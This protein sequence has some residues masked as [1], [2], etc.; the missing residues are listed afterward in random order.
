MIVILL[1]EARP[2]VVSPLHRRPES[3]PP[4]GAAVVT[5][6]G[7]G[8]AERV[9]RWNL[10]ERER[11]KAS[12][13]LTAP[14]LLAGERLR[15]LGHLSGSAAGTGVPNPCMCSD[16]AWGRVS[17]QVSDR[18]SYPASG[19]WV[20]SAHTSAV[21]GIQE[22]R[23]SSERPSGRK[24]D[25]N[26]GI[27]VSTGVR[28]CRTGALTRAN[29]NALCRRVTSRTGLLRRVC[30]HGV[31]TS[32]LSDCQHPIPRLDLHSARLQDLSPPPAEAWP[33]RVPSL[34]CPHN[35]I[36]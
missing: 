31:T 4:T 30:D 16:S 15:P 34:P 20:L 33:R 5:T 6:G 8:R 12:R 17:H 3:P 21:M 29:A 22:G 14:T 2:T 26:T 19:Y 24:G 11:P 35:E 27:G 23:P 32:W 7:R 10:A 9:R 25:L 36:E 18:P 13:R 1:S 28:L